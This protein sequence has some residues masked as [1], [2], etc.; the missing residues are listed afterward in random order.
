LIVLAGGDV[1]LPDR[2][3]PRASVVVDGD[4]IVAVLPRKGADPEGATRV[5]VT[6]CLVAPGFLDVHVH[7]VEGHD[8]LDGPGAVNEVATRLPRFGVTG[9]CPTSVACSPD[10]LA[11][12]LGAVA[13]ARSSG[14]KG[15]ARVIGAHL[16]SNFINPDYKGAQPASRLCSIKAQ[17]SG[18]GFTG[19][20]I[21]HVISRFRESVRI[22]TM[23]PELDSGLELVRQLSTAGHLV[24]I[25][26]SGATYEEASAAIDAGVCHA[27][28]LF[29]RMT[30]MTHRAPGVPG[31]VLESDEV[32]AELICDGFH[33]H[34]SL[35][36]LALRAKGPD[37]IMAISDGTAGSGLPVGSRARLGDETIIVTDRTAVLENGTIAGSVVTMDGVFRTLVRQAGLSVV[38]AA[39]LSATSP[40]RQLGL[41]ETG[42]IEAGFRADLVV[43]GPDLQ[44]R[45]TY[46]SG[47]QWRNPVPSG[48]V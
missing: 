6:G 16:E 19:P 40:A 14:T 5:D 36:R 35:I 1:V 24:S 9:F 34:P 17:T 11:T 42:R 12:F 31:A 23:A 15:A 48:L 3:M 47:I 20:D 13:D 8:V 27:T 33:V 26:H 28:H 39:Q 41:T 10:A 30:P 4:R 37:R 22:V 25:G 45:H 44:V 38:E 2:V 43:L 21:L 7:G 32:A 46:L 18:V 29:N